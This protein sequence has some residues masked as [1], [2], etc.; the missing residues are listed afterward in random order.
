VAGQAPI[1]S[2]ALWLA[3][4]DDNDIGRGVFDA[5]AHGQL[6]GFSLGGSGRAE[7]SLTGNPAYTNCRVVGRGE[8]ALAAW[9][10][11]TDAALDVS[12]T[13]GAP[14]VEPDPRSGQ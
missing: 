4:C 12:M 5:V 2:G 14:A 9:E 7:V 1:P 10:L 3:F 8:Q 13:Q 6:W 11:L